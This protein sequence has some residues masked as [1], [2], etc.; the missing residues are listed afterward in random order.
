M[1]IY[2]VTDSNK[3]RG[4]EIIYERIRDDRKIS[5]DETASQIIINHIKM[6]SK[7]DL[8]PNRNQFILI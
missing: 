8:R 6:Q 7:N 4:Y 3:D 1:E 5:N 2:V